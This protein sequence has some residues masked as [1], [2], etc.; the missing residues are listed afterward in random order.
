MKH[1]NQ[2]CTPPL[3]LTFTS[4]RMIYYYKFLN[5]VKTDG[6]GKGK[7]DFLHYPIHKSLG[8]EIKLMKMILKSLKYLKFIKSNLKRIY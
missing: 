5:Y 6:K 2:I 4:H 1:F 3:P 8:I 7:I